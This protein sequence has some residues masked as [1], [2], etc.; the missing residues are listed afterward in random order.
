MASALCRETTNAVICETTV[1]T[2]HALGY[3][4]EM[5]HLLTYVTSKLYHSLEWYTQV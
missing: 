4:P 1:P 5:L 3:I 2:A